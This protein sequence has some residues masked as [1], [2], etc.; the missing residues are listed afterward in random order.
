MPAARK[1]EIHS[2]RETLVSRQFEQPLDRDDR[3]KRGKR[4]QRN[5]TSIPKM[6]IGVICDGRSAVTHKVNLQGDL[7]RKID[8]SSGLIFLRSSS[9]TFSSSSAFGGRPDESY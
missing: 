7:G 3:A 2:N 4:Q 6:K 8:L 1:V 9:R 5:R